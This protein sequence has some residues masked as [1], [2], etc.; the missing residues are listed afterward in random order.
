M[1]PESKHGTGGAPF[2]REGGERVVCARGARCRRLRAYVCQEGAALR[3]SGDKE[4]AVEEAHAGVKAEAPP[5]AVVQ[6]A[7]QRQAPRER[8]AC[9]TH[10]PALL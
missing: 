2:S 10:F 4:G 6:A 1:R 8:A 5:R 9:E 3:A 7:W